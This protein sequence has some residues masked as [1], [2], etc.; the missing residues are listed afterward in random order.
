MNLIDQVLEL[1]LTMGF[2]CGSS[3]AIREVNSVVAEVACTNI[4]ILLMGESGTGKDAYCRLFHH[5]GI[6]PGKP[7]K[8]MNCPTLDSET[9]RE[10]IKDCCLRNDDRNDSAYGTLFLDQIDELD[11]QCQG[12]LLPLLPDEEVRNG[13]P[14]ISARLVSASVGDLENQIAPEKFRRDLYF[15]IKGV[16]LRL[17]PLRERKEDIPVLFEHFLA[18][19]SKQMGKPVPVVADQDM[20]ALLSHNWPGNIRELQNVAKMGV[21]VGRVQIAVGDLRSASPP[22][23]GPRKSAVS[24]SLKVAARAASRQTEREL[25]LRTLE[26]TRWNRKRAAQE[27]QISYKSLLSKLKQIGD[28]GTTSGNEL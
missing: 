21:V 20:E 25:I 7:I 6:S 8:R 1:G 2:V 4:P 9:F 5:L 19:Y 27:L 17:P 28:S 3:Q 12:L 13:G 22:L 14:E 15:R 11:S 16:S 10:A 18:G 24:S 23:Q 26:R